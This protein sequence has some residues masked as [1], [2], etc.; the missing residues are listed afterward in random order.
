[1]NIHGGYFGKNRKK[2]LDF[3]VNLNPLG[4]PESVKDYI[5]NHLDA[6]DTYPEIEAKTA[7]EQLAVEYDL[8]ASNIIMGNGAVELIYLLARTIKP[9]KVLLLQPTFNEYERAF[10][11]S[12]SECINYSLNSEKAFALELEGILDMIVTNKPEVMIVCNPN[13]PTGTYIGNNILEKIIKTLKL[14][15]GILMVDES[16]SA[17]ENL[18]TAVSLLHHGN[19]FLLRSMTKYYAIAGIRLGYGMGAETIIEKMKLHKEPW[20]LNAIACN[21]VDVLLKDK[22]YQ[23][24]TKEWY[25]EEKAYFLENLKKV[26]FLHAFES[27]ANFFLCRCALDSSEL[28]NRLLEKGIYI[29]TCNDFVNLEEKYIRLAIRQR[30]E[31]KQLF[32]MLFDI[33]DEIGEI[34]KVQ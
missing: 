11:Q 4:V 22:E 18:P 30:V 8:E 31:N 16:F 13:N 5:V 19:V 28:K 1:M 7:R 33:A 25:K 15:G 12:D 9:K 17:F 23:F 26:P 14:H 20:T 21:I 32:Q 6:L 10:V 34:E 27:K 24:K 29:R 3:S 2:I